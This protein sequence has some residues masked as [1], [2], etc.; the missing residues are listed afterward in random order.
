MSSLLSNHKMKI[1][2]KTLVLTLLTATTYAAPTL[3]PVST[4]LQPRQGYNVT[5]FFSGA[6]GAGYTVD[7]LVDSGILQS[8][9]ISKLHPQ[10]SPPWIILVAGLFISWPCH[11]SDIEHSKS[12]KRLLNLRRTCPVLIQRHRRQLYFRSSR[13]VS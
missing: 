10:P 1:L 8:T 12:S 13:H 7:F 11:R 5:V 6:A 4:Q 9:P 2:T 3:E